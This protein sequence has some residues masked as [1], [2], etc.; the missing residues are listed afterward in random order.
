MNAALPAA[1]IASADA[2]SQRQAEVLAALQPL[3]PAH[4]LLWRS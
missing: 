4:A 3:L 1:A 2:R